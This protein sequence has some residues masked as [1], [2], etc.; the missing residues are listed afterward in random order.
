ML[1]SFFDTSLLLKDDFFSVKLVLTSRIV[2][3][4]PCLI[5]K[6]VLQRWMSLSDGYVNFS[7]QFYFFALI[8]FIFFTFF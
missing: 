4:C 7:D 5:N 6:L 3:G 8:F 1:N 2:S